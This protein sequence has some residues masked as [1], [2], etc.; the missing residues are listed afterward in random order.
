MSASEL[1][2]ERFLFRFAV[3][4]GNEFAGSVEPVFGKLLEGNGVEGLYRLDGIGSSK[5][6][7]SKGRLVVGEFE[8]GG[9]GS[10]GAIDLQQAKGFT[11]PSLV[12]SSSW[13]PKRS[14]RRVLTLSRLR[15]M[16][17]RL[18]S[19]AGLERERL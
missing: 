16:A 12:N 3:C 19:S 8:A 5:Q 7:V 11:L 2:G 14:S 10:D 13:E 18:C 9:K 4:A 17:S 15:R 6:S 1:Y